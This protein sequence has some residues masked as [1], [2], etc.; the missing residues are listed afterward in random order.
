MIECACDGDNAFDVIAAHSYSRSFAMP[1]ARNF[2]SK[3]AKQNVKFVSITQS[4]GD[5]DPAQ[6]MMRKVIAL[7]DKYQ[8]KENTEHVLRNVPLW[9]SPARASAFWR[10]PPDVRESKSVSSS[11]SVAGLSA[12][13]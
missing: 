2:I 4:L 3:L 8:S 9:R 13:C 5:N 11:P 12:D 6:A 1:S 10:D 7:F